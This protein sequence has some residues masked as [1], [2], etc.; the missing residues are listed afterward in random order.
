MASIKYCS[1]LGVPCSH[2]SER[3]ADCQWSV[4][5]KTIQHLQCAMA[6]AIIEVVRKEDEEGEQRDNNWK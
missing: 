6:L 2:T 4:G 1:C 5:N 3:L